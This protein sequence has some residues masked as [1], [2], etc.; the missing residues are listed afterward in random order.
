MTYIFI[1][2]ILLLIASTIAIINSS[3][4]AK[5]GKLL[6][7]KYKYIC[8]IPNLMDGEIIRL[9]S[10]EEK[11]KIENLQ[12]QQKYLIPK[13]KVISKSITSSNMLTEKQK[14]VIGRSI[15]GFALGGGVGAIVGGV[16]GVGTKQTTEL[17]NF[18]VINYK[19][20]DN[21][22]QEAMFALL[23]KTHLMYVRMFVNN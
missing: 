2:F 22:E 12:F 20:E 4:N 3:D 18:L 19:D 10:D 13:D 23:D 17:V 5:E 7:L 15:V 8:G 9:S 1:F 11:I 14:S 16:S 21:N 6:S